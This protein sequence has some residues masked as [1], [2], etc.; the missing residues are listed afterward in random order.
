[1]T[2]YKASTVWAGSVLGCVVVLIALGEYFD[3]GYFAFG[4][5]TLI[6]I[7]SPVLLYYWY[8]SEKKEYHAKQGWRK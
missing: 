5:S 4:T 7:I 3:R 8:K 6:L 2:P 1:M